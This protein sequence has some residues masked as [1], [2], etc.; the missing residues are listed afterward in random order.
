[1]TTP[2]FDYEAEHARDLEWEGLRDWYDEQ[3]PWHEDL[4][5]Y[6]EMDMREAGFRPHVINLE[7]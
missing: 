4:D 7:D 6:E 1:M 5:A 2:P 3:K